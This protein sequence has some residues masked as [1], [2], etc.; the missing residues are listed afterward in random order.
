[1]QSGMM[2]LNRQRTILT[3]IQVEQSYAAQ[4]APIHLTIT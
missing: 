3:S 2:I 1:M 4:F